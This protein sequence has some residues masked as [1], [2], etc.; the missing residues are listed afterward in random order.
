MKETYVFVDNYPQ[1]S[2]EGVRVTLVKACDLE[3]AWTEFAQRWAIGNFGLLR[4]S[5]NDDVRKHFGTWLEV[6]EPRNVLDLTESL[7]RYER[8]YEPDPDRDGMKHGQ[9]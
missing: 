8:S 3:S 2:F 6:I 1:R 9:G 7:H 4:N 5:S